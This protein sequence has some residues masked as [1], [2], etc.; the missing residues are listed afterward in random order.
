MIKRYSPETEHIGNGMVLPIMVE[1][2]QGEYVH[3]LDDGRPCHTD[4]FINRML[5]A[6]VPH[7]E[8]PEALVHWNE[9]AWTEALAIVENYEAL[10]EDA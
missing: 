6:G 2:P 10:E 3:M 1:N 5:E 7:Q 4:E 8:M 9:G